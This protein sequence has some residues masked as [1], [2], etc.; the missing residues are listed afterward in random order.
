MPMRRTH[1]ICKASMEARSHESQNYTRVHEHLFMLF[2]WLALASNKNVQKR[3]T[4]QE[5]NELFSVR[6][7]SDMAVGPTSTRQRLPHA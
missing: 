2:E 3:I 6:F 1:P 5:R 7:E 4:K